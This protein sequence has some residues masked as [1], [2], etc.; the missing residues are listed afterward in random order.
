MISKYAFAIA[1]MLCGTHVNAA[2]PT[3][4]DSWVIENI[5]ANTRMAPCEVRRI[6]GAEFPI[7][8]EQYVMSP[9]SRG[10]IQRLVRQ[11]H[12]A[13]RDDEAG[14]PA[15][16]ACAEGEGVRPATNRGRP[17]EGTAPALPA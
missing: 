4:S 13:R 15:F 16:E 12:D 3:P 1:A 17:G 8:A 9:S 11:R 5:A 2:P 14:A 10:R 6:L 7:A